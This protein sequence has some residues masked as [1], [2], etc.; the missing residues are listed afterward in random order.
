MK[1]ETSGSN[2]TREHTGLIMGSGELTLRLASSAKRV[3]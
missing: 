3:G 1:R 2:M